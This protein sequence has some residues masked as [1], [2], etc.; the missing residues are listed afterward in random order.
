MSRPGGGR[1]QASRAALPLLAS[2]ADL[3]APRAAPRHKLTFV[4]TFPTR[5]LVLMVLALASFVWFFWK[6]HSRAPG[7]LTVTP[8]TLDGGAP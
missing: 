2:C 3:L 6:T 4:P 8:V 5:T 7:P 1:S